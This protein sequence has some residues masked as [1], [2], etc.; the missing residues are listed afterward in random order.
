MVIEKDV[1][2]MM[3]EEIPKIRDK[4]SYDLDLEALDSKENAESLLMKH[5]RLIGRLFSESGAP[6]KGGYRDSFNWVESKENSNFIDRK[7]EIFGNKAFL[8]LNEFHQSYFKSKRKGGEKMLQKKG[9]IEMKKEEVDDLEKSFK[10]KMLQKR[11][12]IKIKKAEDQTLFF[13]SEGGD[14][15]VKA[16][17]KA[18]FEVKEV[19]RGDFALLINIRRM[20][21]ELEK[22]IHVSKPK[23][24]SDI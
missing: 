10:Y 3:L 18:K 19:G 1:F 4:L 12:L 8:P 5:R 2:M 16:F 7:F 21:S 23:T 14:D 11:S 24:M 9:S 20:A 17:E 15:L 6:D 13:S 22:S